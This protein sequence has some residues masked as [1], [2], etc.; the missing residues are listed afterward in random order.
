MDVI[1]QSDMDNRKNPFKKFIKLSTLLFLLSIAKTDAQITEDFDSRKDRWFFGG[2]LGMVFGTVT[3][4]QVSPIVGY[5]ITK[6][7]AAGAG[8][9]YEFYKRSD[10][11]KVKTHIYGGNVFTRYFVFPDLGTF[12]PIMGGI[13]IFAQAEFMGLSLE[14]EYFKSPFTATNEEGRF[15]SENYFVG[16]GVFQRIGK[17]SGLYF[18]V[19]YVVNESAESPFT[20]P[21]VRIG[22]NF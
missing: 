16:G 7:L 12:F 4:V 11:V 2:N 22:F 5:Y 14:R 15:F 9:Y 20:N 18:T 19:L 13:A 17:K 6:R 10:F 3:N 1:L 8:P 21:V